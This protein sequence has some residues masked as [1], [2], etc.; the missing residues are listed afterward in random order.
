MILQEIAEYATLRVLEDK[1]NCN[2]ETIKAR[3][4]NMPKGNFAFENALANTKNAVIAEVKK[5]S[6]S[7][8]I[9]S[10]DFPYLA[11][12]KEYENG[13]A[14]CM[15]VLT[16]PKWFMG[17]DE[18][19]AEIRKE[20][21]LP[22]IRKDFTVDEYQLYQ[23]KV[24]GA[25][26]VLLICALLSQTKLEDYL[27]ICNTLGLSAL[28]ET[29]NEDEIAM[30]VKA[31]AKII[32]VN[33]RNLHDFTVDIGNAS[34]LKKSIPENVIFVAESGIQS[35]EDAHELLKN[36]ANALLIGETLM[37]CN[38]KKAFLREISEFCHD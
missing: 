31:G 11:I 2:L 30:A 36:G 32:G 6:P 22:I 14:T 33:N 26:C 19:F 37:R 20:V 24:M 25:D 7:K 8:G 9:I 16:E 1:K 15:S 3:A 13:G 34:S 23:A 12:A 5:A 38:D 10:A 4:L 17:S 27:A 28:V 35:I 21:S 18:I 29:H